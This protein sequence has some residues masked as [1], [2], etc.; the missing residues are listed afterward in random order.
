MVEYEIDE[1]QLQTE[2][3]AIRLGG[4][5]GQ[6]T[7]PTLKSKTVM[8]QPFGCTDFAG[9]PSDPTC[10]SHYKHTG[11]DFAGPIGTP[12]FATD[13]GVA[14]TFAGGGGYGNYVV[15]NHSKGFSTLSAHMI[16]FAVQDNQPVA[17]GDLIGFMG[18]TGFST[19][20]H[21]HYEIRYNNKPIDPCAFI[22]C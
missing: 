16:A 12:I 2:Q 6:F 17:K 21:V 3:Q 11:V 10:P 9:E 7:F 8:T 4:G 1:L 14:R 5:S 18:S 13:A 20:S 22:T 15:I 19:G